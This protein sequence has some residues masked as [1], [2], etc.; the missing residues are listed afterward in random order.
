ML[1]TLS[2]APHNGI[3]AGD[4]AIFERTVRFARP[5]MSV[6]LCAG[7]RDVALARLLADVDRISIVT[8][9]IRSA[10]A[11][12]ELRSLSAALENWSVSALEK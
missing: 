10:Q 1:S 11:L 8:N 2:P 12:W 9:S 7:A 4:R 3:H 5:E 6:A